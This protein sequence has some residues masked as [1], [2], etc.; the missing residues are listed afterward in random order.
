MF[1]LLLLLMQVVHDRRCNVVTNMCIRCAGVDG[2]VQ[3]FSRTKLPSPTKEHGKS[4]VGLYAIV[5]HV[6]QVLYVVGWGVLGQGVELH[7]V[8]G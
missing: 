4:S 3:A 8:G 7:K 5:V 2:L 6:G 1:P